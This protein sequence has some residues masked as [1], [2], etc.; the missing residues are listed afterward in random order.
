MLVLR[1]QTRR[2]IDLRPFRPPNAHEYS[3]RHIRIRWSL[4][5]R[6]AALQVWLRFHVRDASSYSGYSHRIL[7]LTGFLF[8]YFHSPENLEIY[9]RIALALPQIRSP[10]QRVRYLFEYREFY[11]GQSDF[12]KRTYLIRDR[13]RR[14]LPLMSRSRIRSRDPR[15]PTSVEDAVVR[16]LYFVFGKF[17][18]DHRGRA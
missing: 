14:R 10:Q 8:G 12:L 18:H 5:N 6:Q 2:A 9:R 15:Y 7:L 16:L 13:K 1:N 4:S 11:A 3:T 17:G